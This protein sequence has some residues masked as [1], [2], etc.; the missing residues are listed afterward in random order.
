[1][2]VVELIIAFLTTYLL[3]LDSS[4]QHVMILK[5][6]DIFQLELHFEFQGL[7]AV[8]VLGH[9]FDCGNLELV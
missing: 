9:S 4:H 2:Y 6:S 7:Q 5:Q 8:E 1:M 3:F